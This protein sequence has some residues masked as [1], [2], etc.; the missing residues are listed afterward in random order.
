MTEAE[1]PSF[2]IETGHERDLYLVVNRL[3][4]NNSLG[5]C[6]S[7]PSRLLSIANNTTLLTLLS[8]Y[9]LC[10]SSSIRLHYRSGKDCPE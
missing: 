7:S 8:A 9:L 6:T 3:A 5:L 2:I 4:L 10:Y 1:E